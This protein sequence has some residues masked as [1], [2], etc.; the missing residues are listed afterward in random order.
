M[1][2]ETHQQDLQ[3][4]PEQISCGNICL[5]HS[6]HC[7]VVCILHH[8]AQ[9]SVV[10][11]LHHSANYTSMHT[12]PQCTL[13]HSA[14]FTSMHTT[15]QVQIVSFTQ[16]AAANILHFSNPSSTDM[17]GRLKLNMCC[18]RLEVTLNKIFDQFNW[19][20]LFFLF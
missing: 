8:S 9:C 16:R 11:T 13:H 4:L 20:K 12:T 2:E 1:Y 7:G 10:Y 6:A 5:Q 15:A 3:H 19:H 18:I 14:H 17:Y